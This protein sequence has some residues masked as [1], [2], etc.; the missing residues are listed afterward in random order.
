[1]HLPSNSF[2]GVK[3]HFSNIWTTFEFQGHRVYFKVA[4]MCSPR[5]QFNLPMLCA[6]FVG[7][8]ILCVLDVF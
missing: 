2:F 3:V 6:V 1:M 5:R 4:A 7:R 8:V